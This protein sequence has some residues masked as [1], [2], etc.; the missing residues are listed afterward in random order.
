MIL[1]RAFEA[2]LSALSWLVDLLFP[3]TMYLTALFTLAVGAIAL[4]VAR[5]YWSRR[6]S[7]VRATAPEAGKR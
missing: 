4:L 6:A 3:R 2:V 7:L 1:Q 5:R